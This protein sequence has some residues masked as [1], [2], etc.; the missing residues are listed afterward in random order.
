MITF[1]DFCQRLALG[2]LK[3]TAA[4]DS[5]ISRSEIAA[6]HIDTILSLTNQGLIDLST[7]FP[8]ISRQIDLVFQNGKTMYALDESGVGDYLDD[9]ETQEFIAEDFVRVLDI[10]DDEGKSHPHDT[11]GH[12]M[13]PS[14]NTLR[15]TKSKMTDLGEKVR[16]R[17]QSTHGGIDENANIDIPP[18]LITALQLFVASLYISHMNGEEHS[19]KG[20]SYFGAYL[21]HIGNDE[22]KNLSQ[23][24]EVEEDSRFADRGFV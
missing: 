9:S 19:A 5:K 6:E 7:R 15:F 16:I 11:N 10:W 23:T 3:N 2:Q 14:Y 17:Y 21:S 1:S 20:D 13:T 8:L 24:S 22:S 18:N 12:I 4:V